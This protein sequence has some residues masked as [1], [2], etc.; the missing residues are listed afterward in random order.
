MTVSWPQEL[1]DAT[2]SERADRLTYDDED[3]VL[4]AKIPFLWNVHDG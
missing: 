2:G 1:T 4:P 3:I